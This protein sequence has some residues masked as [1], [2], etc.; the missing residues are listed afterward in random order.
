MGVLQGD[1]NV[2]LAQC[3]APV[4]KKKV[5]IPKMQTD[6]SQLD[7]SLLENLKVWRRAA[8]TAQKVPAYLIMHDKTLKQ[9]AASK[10]DTDAKR[11]SADGI[12]K[13]KLDKY[14]AA[15]IGLVAG[16]N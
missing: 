2:E 9:I 10:P 14:G 15:I 16:Q 12:G 7:N 3:I 1:I 11:L 13:A 4:Q 6:L 5:V 8:P